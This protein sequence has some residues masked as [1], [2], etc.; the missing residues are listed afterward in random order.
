[1]NRFIKYLLI[2]VFFIMPSNVNATNLNSNVCSYKSGT[3]CSNYQDNS[4]KATGLV[5]FS[6]RMVSECINGKVVVPK[7][8]SP[9]KKV[10]CSNG[11]TSPQTKLIKSGCPTIGNVCNTGNDLYCSVII[12]YDCNKT[13]SGA[14]YFTT[15]KTSKTTKKTSRIT[16]TTT[17]T[18]ITTQKIINT[19][20]KSL[21]ITNGEISFNPDTY[22]YNIKVKS[23][24]DF[25]NVTAV[26]E[27]NT[28]KVT[29]EGNNNIQN[30]SVIKVIV[31]GSDNQT[32]STY[33]INVEKEVYVK[34]NNAKLKNLNIEGYAIG[35]NSKF[36]EYSLT[37]DKKV[38]S[39]NISYETEDEKATV[40]IIGNDNLSNGS[41]VTVL[42]TA[43]DGTENKYILN[44]TQKKDSNFI[45]I[46]FIIILI[47][48][49][50]A[51]AYYLYKKFVG[52]KTGD[53]YEYE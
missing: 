35:F 42:V 51:G 19:K 13:S 7:Y 32:I 22:V 33:T 17:T 15:K 20:L 14:S 28:S 37:I 5:Y 2:S 50:L 49:I 44:I 45:K 53:K 16:K 24:V 1:M 30:G 10:T 39:L 18:S 31:T 34:S 41:Q 40:N 25:I 43:E 27:D 3:T 46:L 11:N 12:S 9:E 29:V 4:I 6:H 36:N 38:K 23:D 47:L 48:A 26:A 52:S 21:N 8:I